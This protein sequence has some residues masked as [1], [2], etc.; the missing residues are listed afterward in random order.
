M[1]FHYGGV[2][3]WVAKKR[4]TK[5]TSPDVHW[6]IWPRQCIGDRYNAGQTQEKTY[7][8]PQ[9]SRSLGDTQEQLRTR[10]GLNEDMGAYVKTDIWDPVLKT[11]DAWRIVGGEGGRTNPS[12]VLS[13]F[14]LIHCISLSH[15]LPLS[16]K[17]FHCL[18]LSWLSHINS[19]LH[20]CSFKPL[21][22]TSA[23]LI[24]I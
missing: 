15:S 18:F 17:A 16:S 6:G 14:P 22:M 7:I 4:E 24:E 8:W 11:M 13:L 20:L 19:P 9:N 21:K 12:W 5:S 1:V 2:L 3:Y 23:I 10:K